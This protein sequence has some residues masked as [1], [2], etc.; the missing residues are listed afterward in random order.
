MSDSLDSDLRFSNWID[1]KYALA[2]EIKLIKSSFLYVSQN[3]N[4]AVLCNKFWILSISLAP[5]NSINILPD[6]PSLW[7]LGWVTPNLSIRFLKTSKAEIID[8]SIFTLIIDFISSSE[9][10]NETSELN[11]LFPKISGDVNL[12]GSEFDSNASKKDSKYVWSDC[13]WSSS[14]L[15][16]AW[17][18]FWFIEFSERPFKRSLI[19]IWSITLIPPFK[20]NP[21]FNSFCFASL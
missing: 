5:G 8:S 2:E 3:S 6:E 19:E 4:C 7:I 17:L 18:N 10:S 12:V 14:A 21:W 20:S 15:S 9:V 11:V 13:F 16:K 1:D